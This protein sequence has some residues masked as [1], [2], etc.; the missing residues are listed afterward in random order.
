M[1]DSVRY[2]GS[3][4][5]LSLEKRRGDCTK[6]FHIHRDRGLGVSGMLAANVRNRRSAGHWPGHLG[7]AYTGVSAM[8]ID[9]IMQMIVVTD[10]AGEYT[11]GSSFQT[12]S[13]SG[14]GN[15]L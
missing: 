2:T 12:T 1:Q 7:L 6:L 3:R 15:Q 14:R 11:Q 10:H 4:A 8:T 5:L 13:P 9:A